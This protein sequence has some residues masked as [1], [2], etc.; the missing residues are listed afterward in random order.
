MAYSNFYVLPPVEVTDDAT[1]DLVT[2]PKHS[3]RDDVHSFDG[4]LAPPPGA[5]SG[6][7]NDDGEV[8]FVAVHAEQA[9]HDAL[10]GDGD[11]LHVGDMP[12][13]DVPREALSEA[14]NAKYRPQNLGEL[15]A[16]VGRAL[17]RPDEFRDLDPDEWATRLGAGESVF[18]E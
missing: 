18:T 4:G 11:V 16:Q 1:G 9:A 7:T 8:Y 6:P 3:D 2:I 13:A 5:Y 10:Q 14:F 12:S 15:K 17:G